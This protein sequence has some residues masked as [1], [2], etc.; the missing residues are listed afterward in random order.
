MAKKNVQKRK[1]RPKRSIKG[2]GDDHPQGLW[3]NV[4]FFRKLTTHEGRTVVHGEAGET[5]NH[6]LELADLVLN[7]K[8]KKK[9]K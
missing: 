4:D 7:D 6:Y 5:Q 8:Q 1:A 3:V 9:N 2:K